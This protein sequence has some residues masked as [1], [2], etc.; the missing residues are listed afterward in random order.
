VFENDAFVP[1]PTSYTVSVSSDFTYNVASPSFG[2]I[3]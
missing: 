3:V 1:R 2:A